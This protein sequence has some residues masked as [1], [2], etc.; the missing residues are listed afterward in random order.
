MLCSNQQ[1]ERQRRLETFL[2]C[3]VLLT[4]FDGNEAG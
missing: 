1:R 4:N 2:Q 3:S